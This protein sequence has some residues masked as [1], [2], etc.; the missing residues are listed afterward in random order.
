M[1]IYKYPREE[2]RGEKKMELWWGALSWWIFLIIGGAMA[3]VPIVLLY[4]GKGK[5]IKEKPDIPQEKDV[6]LL[7]DKIVRLRNYVQLL[8]EETEE[9]KVTV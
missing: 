4:S 7:L 8:E 5:V 1:R 2:K 9:E 6:Q 3:I